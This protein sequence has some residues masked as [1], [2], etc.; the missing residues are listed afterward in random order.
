MDQKNREIND[1][2]NTDPELMYSNYSTDHL[3]DLQ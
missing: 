1:D 3:E 2:Q